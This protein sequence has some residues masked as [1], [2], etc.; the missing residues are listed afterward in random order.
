M[1]KTANK[2][3]S[4]KARSKYQNNKQRQLAARER[5]NKVTGAQQSANNNETTA[6]DQKGNATA[7]TAMTEAAARNGTDSEDD[8]EQCACCLGT[9]RQNATRIICQVC[10]G[11]FHFTCTGV[12]EQARRSFM[13]TVKQVGWVCNDCKITAHS[14]FNDLQI[15]IAELAETVAALQEEVRNIRAST[16]AMSVTQPAQT[17]ASTGS[18]AAEQQRAPEAI[19]Q[20]PGPSEFDVAVQHIL[21]ETD[22]RKRN[23]IVTGLIERPGTS[24]EKLFSDLCETYLQCKPL[25]TNCMRIGKSSDSRQRKLLVRLRNDEIASQLL[26][27]AKR[28]HHTSDASISR[29]VYIN[30]DLSPAAAKL[31]FDKRQRRRGKGNNRRTGNIDTKHRNCTQST[32]YEIASTAADYNPQDLNQQE[33]TNQAGATKHSEQPQVLNPNAQPFL[34]EQ[35]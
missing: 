22:R 6:A 35:Q 23:V 25:I 24:D 32:N 20:R 15:K 9:L 13:E 26:K 14:A 7:N 33:A 21:Q 16:V 34:R 12:P 27:D 2:N 28:L 31:A 1:N 8:A 10:S 30:P 17:T 11:C 19:G 29:A 4:A 3:A 5:D 18:M